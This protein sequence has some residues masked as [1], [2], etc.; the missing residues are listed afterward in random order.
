MAKTAA[1]LQAHHNHHARMGRP[2]PERHG[3]R[4]GTAVSRRSELHCC[5]GPAGRRLAPGPSQGW[6][7]GPERP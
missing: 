7:G 5:R 1:R 4:A 3:I 6:G 2:A